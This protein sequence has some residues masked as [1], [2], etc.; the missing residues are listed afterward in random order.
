MPEAL[1]TKAMCDGW[2][3]TAAAIDAEVLEVARAEA[4]EVFRVYGWVRY[5]QG[6]GF[7]DDQVYHSRL[8]RRG[9]AYYAREGRYERRLLTHPDAAALPGDWGQ[10]STVMRIAE[11][12]GPGLVRL[13]EV[14]AGALLHALTPPDDA[15]EFTARP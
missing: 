8:M 1:P 11:D 2:L 3:L 12:L 9:W 7:K 4:D 15:S 10:L 14:L 5:R 6:M 13:D